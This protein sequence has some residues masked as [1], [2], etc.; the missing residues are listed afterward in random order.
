MSDEP[1]PDLGKLLRL[2]AVLRSPEGCPWDREQQLGDLRAYLIEESHEVA[3]AIDE[4]TEGEVGGWDGLCGELGDLL[5]Q[6]AF[7]ATLAKEAGA[8]DLTEVIDTVHAKM[9]E[10]HPHVFGGDEELETADAVR[11]QW[12]QRKLSKAADGESLLA[13]VP[14]SL[15][16]LTG[17]YRIGQKV[18]GVGF[19]WPDATAVADK[20]REELAEV[21][22]AA[23]PAAGEA[24]DA[25]VMEEVGDL[26]FSAANLARHLKV[27]P[28]AALA[29]GN[30]KFRRRFKALEEAF[31]SRGRSLPDAGIEELEA[32]W[33]AVKRRERTPPP[34]P[35]EDP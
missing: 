33:E 23:D 16:A 19:D 20:V 32:E 30:L 6:V 21:E 26:L 14:A 9:V 1:A 5:F 12:E 29:G 18:A 28:E 25:R 8:F 13:G 24:V 7:V 35:C 27:D 10:R 2:I 4:V 17:A 22:S 34:R 3:A 31:A 15:P 11:Q